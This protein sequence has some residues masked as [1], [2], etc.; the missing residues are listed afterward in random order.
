MNNEQSSIIDLIKSIRFC[1]AM[2]KIRAEIAEIEAG[3]L[4]KDNN[5]LVNAPHPAGV[6]LAEQW[7]RYGTT[8]VPASKLH[9]NEAVPTRI[10]LLPCYAALLQYLKRVCVNSPAAT[11]STNRRSTAEL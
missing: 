4:P 9:H 7:D 5:P 1:E 10:V 6:V 11:L 2:I 3:R 8:V